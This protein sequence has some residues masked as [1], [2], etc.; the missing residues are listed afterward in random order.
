MI[1][2]EKIFI[3]DKNLLKKY[4]ED[5]CKP[6]EKWGIGAEYENFIFSKRKIYN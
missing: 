6:K 4:F 1:D 2:K 5:G 3:S